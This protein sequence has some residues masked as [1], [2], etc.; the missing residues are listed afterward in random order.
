MI[1]HL[2]F[3]HEQVKASEGMTQ[4][5]AATLVRQQVS[6]CVGSPQLPTHEVLPL[7][8]SQTSGSEQSSGTEGQSWGER[9]NTHPTVAVVLQIHFFVDVTLCT[10]SELHLQ[11]STARLRKARGPARCSLCLPWKQ[12]QLHPLSPSGKGWR[13]T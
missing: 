8:G 9:G 7:T 13:T 1:Q 10:P 11:G 3:T 2:H 6:V 12:C 4:R 5:E